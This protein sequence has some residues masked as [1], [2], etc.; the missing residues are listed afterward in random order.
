M[1]SQGLADSRLRVKVIGGGCSGFS[2]DMAFD[3]ADP[4]ADGP[5]A[6]KKNDPYNENRDVKFEELG[7]TL[8]VDQMS[9]MYIYGTTIDYVEDLVE[10]GFKFN[11][12]NTTS[13][14]GCN[15]SFTV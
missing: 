7:V 3:E 12:P 4:D 1:D 8:I 9:L 6:C 14:C 10:S 13:T 15:K 2:Y 11:N 5:V